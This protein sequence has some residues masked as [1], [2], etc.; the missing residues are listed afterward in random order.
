MSDKRY[1]RKHLSRR[2]LEWRAVLD[3]H[4]CILN[5]EWE[6]GYNTPYYS[7][8]F[9]GK[10][11]RMVLLRDEEP[12]CAGMYHI[13]QYVMKLRGINHWFEGVK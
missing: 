8:G 3:R 5:F 13:T 1:S 4:L 11:R 9:R 6:L 10:N 12:V 2:F 7:I